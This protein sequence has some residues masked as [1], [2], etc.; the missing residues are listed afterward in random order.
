MPGNHAVDEVCSY[1]GRE[2]NI[3]MLKISPGE[4]RQSE[5]SIAT[6]AESNK[7][8]RITVKHEM[9]IQL[10][11][12]TV[13][14]TLNTR[15]RLATSLCVHAKSSFHFVTVSTCTEPVIKWTI[16]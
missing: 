10:R 5:D 11:T 13:Q 14:E 3:A 16:P 15:R 7:A 2:F 8:D 9:N 6:N 12:A 4:I 1:R